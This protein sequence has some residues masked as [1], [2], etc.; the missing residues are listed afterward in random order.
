MR[1]YLIL[2]FAAVLIFVPS[3]KYDFSQDDFIHLYHSR[4]SSLQDV[5]NFFNPNNSYTDIF[6]YRPLT[7]QFYFFINQLLFGIN[8]LPFRIE[9]L[10]GHL[11][12]GFLFYLIVRKLWQDE[13]VAK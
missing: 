13:L 11:V 10:V 6:F 9:A 2:L 7:T 8:A 3:L 4:A 12:N 5:I 1:L